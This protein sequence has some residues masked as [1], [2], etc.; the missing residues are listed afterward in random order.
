MTLDWVPRGYSYIRELGSG[1]CGEVALARHDPLDRLVAIKRIHRWAIND[2][3]ALRRFRREGRVLAGL[4]H[5]AIVRVY[6]FKL[7]TDNALLIMEYVPGRPL[8]D[9]VSDGAL[10]AGEGLT[11]LGD[12]AAALAAAAS[13]G[14]IHRDVKPGNVF[15]LP[16]GRA[17]LGDFGLA[18]VV[19]DPAVFRTTDG[20]AGGTPAYFP[21][22]VSQG[23]CEPDER[24]DAYSFAVMAYEVL[25]GRQPFVGDDPLTMIAAHWH[26]NAEAPHDFIRGFPR[27]AS[28]ALLAG[29]DRQPERRPL[30]QALMTWLAAVPASDWPAAG[31]AP[32][33]GDEAR[34]G[35]V[36][37]RRVP[38]RAPATPPPP[39]RMPRRSRRVPLIVGLVL[40][41][42]VVAAGLTRLLLAQPKQIPLS[43]RSVSVH[44]RP[45]PPVAHCPAAHFEFIAVIVTNGSAGTLAV[46]WTKPD[47]RL[48]SVQEISVPSGHKNVSTGLRFA[49][50]GTNP[51]HG[52][53]MVHV[54]SPGKVDA[55]ST[56]IDYHC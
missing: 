25:T 44:T 40:L 14:V 42:G 34:A 3:D 18:R 38:I 54:L 5:P 46:Q 7:T 1:A 24:S 53:A 13:A 43:V 12:V 23:S 8:S 10:A 56:Q 47:G 17:K 11:A 2:D 26:Q 51:L 37:T 28:T 21:P 36:A 22:E 20:Q 19:T 6:D 32:G 30:P 52:T 9:L 50:S 33:P 48:S 4:H 45:E 41:V 15:V 16:D 49:V 35:T 27:A 39:V 29:L 55:T 31:R